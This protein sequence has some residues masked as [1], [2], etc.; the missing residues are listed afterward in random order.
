MAWS[1]GLAVASAAAVACSALVG[2]EDVR[3]GRPADGGAAES[4]KRP[5]SPGNDGAAPGEASVQL[6]LG[7]LHTCARKG[8]GKVSCWGD[9]GAGQL[10]D[11]IPFDGGARAP[12][13]VPQGVPGIDDAVKLA[14]GVS[15]SCVVRR[16]GTVS[17]WGINTS[18]QLGRASVPRSS[19][20]VDVVGI[21]TA[22]DIA[23]GTSF[24]CA[25]LMGGTVSCWGANSSGQL[26][27]GTKVERATAAPVSQLTDVTS[28]AAAESHACAIVIGGAVKC[29]GR[30]TD[31]Q[32][33]NGTTVD[34]L[35]P[36]ALGT[37]SGVAQI[38][39]ASHFTCARLIS[40]QLNCW[41]TNADGQLGTGTSSIAPNP[42]P[43]I[44]KVSD[45]IAV[46]V[47]YTHA[48]AVRRTGDVACWGAAGSGQ[49]G[50][51]QVPADASVPSPAAVLGVTGA[52]DVSTGGDHSCAMTGTGAVLCW[53]NN[54]FGQLGDGTTKG[55]YA[56]VP[57]MTFP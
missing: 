2:V 56:A 25:L 1:F 52:L 27:D 7:Y 38:V 13:L 26:G 8:D 30:N 21:T 32:L 39:A 49:V 28:L 33:G 40:G 53:G 14:S 6:A 54:V 9:N 5:Q 41:G 51:G 29:W 19:S 3:L 34:S 18:G 24:T 44:T 37:L 10:G 47:G 46:S 23:C 36:T 50:S 43:A 55:A 48:C 12:A 11:G 15:H 31:G 16:S 4:G 35:V 45:A 42:T 57:V 17:C 22:V 20:P